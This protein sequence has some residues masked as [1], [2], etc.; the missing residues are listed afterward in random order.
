MPRSCCA[1]A[2]PEFA[3]LGM[4][5]TSSG[6]EGGLSYADQDAGARSSLSAAVREGIGASIDDIFT[7]SPGLLASRGERTATPMA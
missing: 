6:T 2:L 3:S 5:L 1:L 4:V 7:S